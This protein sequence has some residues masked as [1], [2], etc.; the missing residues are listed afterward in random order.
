M[1]KHLTE[2]VKFLDR[3]ES[4]MDFSAWLSEEIMPVSVISLRTG[5]AH[6]QLRLNAEKS[7][8]MIEALHKHIE[9]I[10]TL[11]LELIAQA[12]KQAA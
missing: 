7:Q 6:F 4:E 10:K 8:E 1:G 2:T 11:E 3:I 12:Q 9:N 5:Y